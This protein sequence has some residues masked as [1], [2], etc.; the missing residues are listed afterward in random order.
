MSQTFAI[1][2]ERLLLRTWREGDTEPFFKICSDPEVMR[3]FPEPLTLHKTEKLIG[4]GR[5][6]LETYG[7]F[8]SP[9]EVKATGE[10]IGFVG[11]VVHEDSNALPIAPCIDIGWRLKRSAWGKGYASEAA[12]AWLRF[13]FE[14]KG[15]EE[16]VSFT[17]AI[18]EPSQKV[19]L[20]LGM[21]RDPKED[22]NHPYFSKDHRLALHRL[23]RMSRDT[24][25]GRSRDGAGTERC[26]EPLLQL[27]NPTEIFSEAES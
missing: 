10:L 17:P 14:T 27:G 13:G 1:E 26:G 9:V 5:A 20:R 24:W 6:C 7:V 4:M 22:F 19:M 3:H 18:N 25:V 12:A 21:I 8:Y 23:Y 11:L 15:Y 16:I 2:T